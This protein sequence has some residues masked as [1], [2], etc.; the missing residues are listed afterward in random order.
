M[1]KS[2][3]HTLTLSYSFNLSFTHTKH[4]EQLLFSCLCSNVAVYRWKCRWFFFDKTFSSTLSSIFPF[5]ELVPSEKSQAELMVPCSTHW[6]Q[7]INL[8]W[9]LASELTCGKLDLASCQLAVSL[10]TCWQL[11]TCKIGLALCNLQAWIGHWIQTDILE[12]ETKKNGPTCYNPRTP[13]RA[14]S[15]KSIQFIF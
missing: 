2:H 11:A 15:R 12:Q 14:T 9:Q 13:N 4:A 6:W 10:L 1:L 8:G 5:I 7:V 3:F